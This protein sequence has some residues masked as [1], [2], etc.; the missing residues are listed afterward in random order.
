MAE[1]GIITGIVQLAG[2]AIVSAQTLCDLVD[3]VKN[4]PEGITA[5]SKDAHAFRNVISAVQSALRHPSVERVI[6]ED[7]KLTELIEGLGE[8]LKNSASTLALLDSKIKPHLKPAEDGGS[9]MSSID[10]AWY[11]KK[12]EIMDC[13]ASLEATKSTLDTALNSVIFLCS[14]R[15]ASCDSDFVSSQETPSEKQDLDAGSLLIK[16]AES[17][18]PR[19]PS[20]SPIKEYAISDSS[21]DIGVPTPPESRTDPLERLQTMQNQRSE[22]LH[23]S[24]D[25]DDLVNIKAGDGRT[26]LHVA[27]QYGHDDVVKTLMSKGAN[28]NVKSKSN[29]QGTEDQRKF[30]AGRSPLHWAAAEGHEAVVRILFDHHADPL[31]RNATGRT[32]LQDSIMNMHNGIAL[33]LLEKGSSI[34]NVDN[35]NWSPL[36][37]ACFWGQDDIVKALIQRGKETR[38]FPAMLNVTTTMQNRWNVYWLRRATPLFIAAYRGHV[39]C[40]EYLLSCGASNSKYGDTPLHVACVLGNLPIVRKLLEAGVDIELR[41]SVFDETPLLKA[42]STGQTAVVK[43]LLEQGADTAALNQHGRNAL[44]HARWHEP[45]RHPDAV[46]L[47]EKWMGKHRLTE[48]SNITNKDDFS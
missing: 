2:A 34:T 47:F 41:D 46:D 8:P 36:H 31:S 21:S 20:P 23:A 10:L 16:Y 22:L 13:K 24:Q 30:E 9:R 43:H 29:I 17:I 7:E 39:E 5:I 14:V 18:A 33:L 28:V 27:A 11:F 38:D 44:E 15:S 12:R 3:T 32:A 26:A 1:L 35:E 4:A 19:S 40:V 25:G 42:A 45:G 6:V 37:E 48:D